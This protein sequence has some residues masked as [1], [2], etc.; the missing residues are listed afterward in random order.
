M[1]LPEINHFVNIS[2]LQHLYWIWQVTKWES[3]SLF[4]LL[5][6]GNK[7]KLW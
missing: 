2:R 6:K 1:F 5:D 7:E 3:L 4:W